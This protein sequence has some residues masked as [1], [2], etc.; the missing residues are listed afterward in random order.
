[1]T[2]FP[3]KLCVIVVVAMLLVWP[4]EVYSERESLCSA[5]HVFMETVFRIASFD[6]EQRSRVTQY[7]A[8]I[9]ELMR[10]A[11]RHLGPFWDPRLF[12]RDVIEYVRH[13]ETY[14]APPP[15][16]TPK[17][18]RENIILFSDIARTGLRVD[19][20]LLGWCDQ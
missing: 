1:M 17:A 6:E 9:D 3:A 2:A 12:K 7:S 20:N 11:R 14:R 16:W 8:A 10:V 15:G 13:Q 4:T 18:S 19:L 5:L